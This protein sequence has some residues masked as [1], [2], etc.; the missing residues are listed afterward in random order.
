M[1]ATILRLHF[2]WGGSQTEQTDVKKDLRSSIFHHTGAF[3]LELGIVPII[4][5]S[6][7][8]RIQYLHNLAKREEDQLIQQFLTVQ[9]NNP[10]R[11]DWTESVTENL[12]EFGIPDDIEYLKSKTKESFKNMMKKKARKVALTLPL[13]IEMKHFKMENLEHEISNIVDLTALRL[14][15]L[16]GYE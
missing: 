4:V 8:R 12:N 16:M 9:W 7:T 10:I 3:Y 5:V 1:E 13:N 2:S 14:A 6:N 11:I 15:F